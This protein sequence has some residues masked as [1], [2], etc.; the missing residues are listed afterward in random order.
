MFTLFVRNRFAADPISFAGE[1]LMVGSWLAKG[2]TGGKGIAMN[3]P[4]CLPRGSSQGRFAP[5]Q[6]SLRASHV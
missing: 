1:R 6:Q 3:T 4:A 2:K 5:A